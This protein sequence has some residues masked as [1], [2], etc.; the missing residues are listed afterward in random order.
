MKTEISIPRVMSTPCAKTHHFH[1]MSVGCGIIFHYPRT[2]FSYHNVES[3]THNEVLKHVFSISKQLYS[4]MDKSTALFVTT[5]GSGSKHIYCFKILKKNHILEI[6]EKIEI[7]RHNKDK[8]A[9]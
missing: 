2:Y 6:V 4:Y 8:N 9:F 1:T 7:V 3:I 5:A